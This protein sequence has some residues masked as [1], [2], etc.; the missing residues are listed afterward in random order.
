[1]MR[2]NTGQRHTGSSGRVKLDCTQP[3][4]ES[5]SVTWTHVLSSPAGPDSMTSVPR[6]SCATAGAVDDGV[7]RSV[8][9]ATAVIRTASDGADARMME[10]DAMKQVTR[11]KVPDCM[12]VERRDRAMS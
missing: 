10:D 9:L 4:R 5:G 7:A 6:G 1:M 2:S 11:T 12:R 3:A 8:T